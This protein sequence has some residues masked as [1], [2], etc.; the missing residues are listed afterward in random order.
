MDGG[1]KLTREVGGVTV[2]EVPAMRQVHRQDLV[3]RLDAGEVNGGIGLAARVRLDVG[4]VSAE[5]GLGP[6]NRELLDLVDLFTATIPALTGVTFGILVR[7]DAALR[8]HDRR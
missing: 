4:V 1:I 2:R 7:E 6:V 8:F 3:T 5:E